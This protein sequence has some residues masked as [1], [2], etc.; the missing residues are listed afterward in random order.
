MSQYEVE[1][2]VYKKFHSVTHNDI[3]R[4]MGEYDEE[5]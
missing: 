3:K 5:N 4:V 1:D 2:I